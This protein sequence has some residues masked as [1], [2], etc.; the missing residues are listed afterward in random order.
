MDILKTIAEADL[1][2]AWQAPYS[3]EA[4]NRKSKNLPTG[5]VRGF[6]PIPVGGFADRVRLSRDVVTTTSV[7]NIGYDK[8]MICYQSLIDVEIQLIANANLQFIALRADYTV[9][10]STTGEV[11]SYTQAEYESGTLESDEAVLVCAVLYDGVNPIDYNL[12]WHSGSTSTTFKPFKRNE[13]LLNNS[14]IGRSPMELEFSDDFDRNTFLTW[15]NDEIIGVDVTASID[16][17][18]FLTGHGSTK[19]TSSNTSSARLAGVSKK[20]IQVHNDPNGLK[21]ATFVIEGMIKFGV[22]FVPCDVGVCFNVVYEDGTLFPGFLLSDTHFEWIKDFST[23]WHLFRTEFIIEEHGTFGKPLLVN[24]T[25]IAMDTSTPGLQ[26]DFTIDSV[27]IWQY[28]F[29]SEEHGY[30]D[31]DYPKLDPASN[32]YR[33]LIDSSV[34]IVEPDDDDVFYT[35]APATRGLWLRSHKNGKGYLLGD[36]KVIASA[37]RKSSP[38]GMY[39]KTNDEFDIQG[40]KPRFENPLNAIMQPVA[41]YV[42]SMDGSIK[43]VEYNCSYNGGATGYGSLGGI[44]DPIDGSPL[45]AMDVVVTVTANRGASL[46]NPVVVS[47]HRD[48]NPSYRIG[49]S[50]YEL[51]SNAYTDSVGITIIVFRKIVLPDF[52]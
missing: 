16:N 42:G 9:G 35:V 31:T 12:I 19:I 30:G 25:I 7:A 11:V 44:L 27:R 17:S 6:S 2:I 8:Y 46:S 20:F 51:V 49:I 41:M 33:G 52:P 37:S 29:P 3:S 18:D 21:P 39:G 34:T 48:P 26:G 28:M 45:L 40:Y 43:E 36:K 32:G 47:C 13:I 1:S 15:E 4:S 24:P 5:I 14:S 10:S 23:S 38:V 50:A 22:T